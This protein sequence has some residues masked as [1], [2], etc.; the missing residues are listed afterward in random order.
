MSM[1]L[2]GVDAMLADIRQRMGNAT[3]KLERDGLRAAGEL[4]AEEERS[5]VAFSDK[6]V[7]IHIRDDIYVSR[8]VRKDGMKYVLVRTSKKTSWRV[9]FVEYGT[10][11]QSARPFKEPAFRARKGQALAAMVE[12]FRGGLR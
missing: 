3:A 12:V 7:G 6:Q 9:H 1:E 5:L 8:V 10:S 2:Q 11:T 4:I